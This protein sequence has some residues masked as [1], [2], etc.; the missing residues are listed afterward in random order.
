MGLAF[1]AL[2]KDV[3]PPAPLCLAGYAARTLIC[4]GCLDETA[5]VPLALALPLSKDL[6]PCNLPVLFVPPLFLLLLLLVLL[7][8]GSPLLRLLAPI[9]L[10]WLLAPIPLLGLLVPVLLCLWVCA[11][12]SREWCSQLRMRSWA[13]SASRILLLLKDYCMT[14]PVVLYYNCCCSCVWV[15][16][17]RSGDWCDRL[18]KNSSIAFPS[19]FSTPPPSSL[20]SPFPFP[21]LCG[22]KSC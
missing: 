6:A 1:P 19:T 7:V 22:C 15:S 18:S 14:I 11:S 9:P 12:L 10:L 20:P 3:V 21:S 5:E 16:P 4:S 2:V 13:A 17:L 8:V